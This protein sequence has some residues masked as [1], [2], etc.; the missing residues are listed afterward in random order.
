MW[1]KVKAVGLPRNPEE[2]LQ[3]IDAITILQSRSKRVPHCPS[4]F[5][6]NLVKFVFI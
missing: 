5:L 4:K 2:D 3:A 1:A 6:I